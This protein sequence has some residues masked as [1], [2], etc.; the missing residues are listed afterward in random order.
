[1]LMNFISEIMYTSE[2]CQFFIWEFSKLK[3]Y[4]K[5]LWLQITISQYK[6][7]LR[8]PREGALTHWAVAQNS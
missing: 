3:I 4:K 2:S 1:M 8:E 6:Y 7:P 5:S